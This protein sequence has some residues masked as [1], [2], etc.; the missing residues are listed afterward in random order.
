METKSYF[1][2]K[3]RFSHFLQI[4]RNHFHLFVSVHGYDR[5]GR[6]NI[7]TDDDIIHRDVDLNQVGNLIER[8]LTVVEKRIPQDLR[9]YPLLVG[10]DV[11]H[12]DDGE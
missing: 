2:F 1:T 8:E 11:L 6:C 5:D 4:E 9:K 3:I 10:H 12:P 7:K